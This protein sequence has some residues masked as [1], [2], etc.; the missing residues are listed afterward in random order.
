MWGG[1]FSSAEME[2]RE[3]FLDMAR[4][5]FLLEFIEMCSS[6]A[7][8]EESGYFREMARYSTK[9]FGAG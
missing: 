2:W 9:D 6:L 3:M 1:L 5:I 8:G 7:L 4:Y